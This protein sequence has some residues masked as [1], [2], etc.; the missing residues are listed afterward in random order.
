MISRAGLTWGFKGVMTLSLLGAVFLVAGEVGAADW[1]LLVQADKMQLAAVFALCAPLIVF[2]ALKWQAVVNRVA[3]DKYLDW[4]GAVRGYLGALPLS[5]LTPGKLG[6]LVRVVF[7]PPARRRF[8]WGVFAMAIDKLTDAIS[9]LIWAI[10]AVCVVFPSALV[11]GLS[12]MV[13]L[14]LVIAWRP[15]MFFGFGLAMR[16][17]VLRR[18]F[19]YKIRQ[20]LLAVRNFSTRQMLMP[21]VF[22][23]LSFGVEWLQYWLVFTAFGPGRADFGF[24]VV[25][26]AM[27][28]VTIAGLVQITIGGVGVRELLSVVLLTAYLDPLAVAA[29]TLLVFVV[30]QIIP[31]FVGLPIRPE[32]E[33][34]ARLKFVDG[35]A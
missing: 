15:M 11:I 26:L 18:R 17:P 25:I 3:E 16:L 24:F 7:L 22:G 2:K 33:P 23:L 35:K 31:A 19:G 5:I 21:T 29:G 4:R 9:L 30:D 32:F 14:L 1:K 20:I 28:I 27:C 10:V 8:Q 13:L 34:E 6:D 12:V